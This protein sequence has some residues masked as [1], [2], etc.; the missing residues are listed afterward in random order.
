MSR[1]G[2]ACRTRGGLLEER[3]VRWGDGPGIVPLG[4]FFQGVLGPI[5]RRTLTATTGTTTI[6]VAVATIVVV[7]TVVVTIVVAVTI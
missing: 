2:S 4:S 3:R 6:A 1:A 7:A 5:L